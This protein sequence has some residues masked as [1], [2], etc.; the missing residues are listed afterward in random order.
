M[1]LSSIW[2]T[3]DVKLVHWVKLVRIESQVAIFV[4]KTM[5]LDS[6]KLCVATEN[7]RYQKVASA[8]VQC[9]LLVTLFVSLGN[10]L[11]STR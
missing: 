11:L 7:R 2:L 5:L 6:S 4:P 1:I 10:R 9:Y 8:I 3:V